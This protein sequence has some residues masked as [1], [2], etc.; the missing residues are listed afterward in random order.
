VNSHEELSRSSST[1][2]CLV[3]FRGG[4]PNVTG[5]WNIHQSVA[6]NEADSQ[7]NLVQTENTI[8][9]SC[10]S[11]EGKDLLVKGAMEGNKAT[12]QFESDYN[13]TQLT[14]KFTGTIDDPGKMSGSVDVV[15][16]F[17]TVGTRLISVAIRAIELIPRAN[18]RPN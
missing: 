16:A 13:G 2:L 4:A 5:K 17:E 1:P 7:C 18:S 12:W 10:K 14:I 3:S 9:R 6:G 11:R 15:R 8:G